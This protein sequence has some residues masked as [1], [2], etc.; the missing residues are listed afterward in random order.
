MSRPAGEKGPLGFQGRG[1]G[2]G[3][4]GNIFFLKLSHPEKKSGTLWSTADCG[5]QAAGG[6]HSTGQLVSRTSIQPFPKEEA[7]RAELCSDCNRS[8]QCVW[9][10]LYPFE[11]QPL[12]PQGIAILCVNSS[13]TKVPPL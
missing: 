8:N 7:P 6:S 13:F 12:L 3:E 4:E 10:F 9:A 1:T 2:L 11:R 5:E